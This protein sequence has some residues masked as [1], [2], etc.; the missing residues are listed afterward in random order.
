MLGWSK[1]CFALK[2]CRRIKKMEVEGIEI[3]NLKDK[4]AKYLSLTDMIKA[5]DGEFL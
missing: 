3:T 2:L 5:K 4:A 1:P